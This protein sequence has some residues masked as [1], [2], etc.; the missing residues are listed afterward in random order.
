MKSPL[1]KR[2][3]RSGDFPAAGSNDRTGI[4]F[5]GCRWQYDYCLQ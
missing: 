4:R 1:R 5:S 3:S 2:L